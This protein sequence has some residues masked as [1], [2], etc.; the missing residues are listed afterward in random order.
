MAQ[1]RLRYVSIAATMLFAC[2]GGGDGEPGIDAAVDAAYTTGTYHA[3]FGPLTVQP[4]EENTKCVEVRLGNTANIQVHEIANHLGPMSHH[5]IVYRKSTGEAR[6]EPYDCQPFTSALNPAN[7]SPLM[8][9]QRGDEVLTLP[10]DVV[11]TLQPDQLIRLELHYIN[12]GDEPMDVTATAEFRTLLGAST[13]ADFIF[14]G[15][16]D[17]RLPSRPGIQTVGPVYLPLPGDFGGSNVF[18]ITGHT[19][20]LGKTVTVETA[21][22]K[23][24]PGTMVYDP[25]LFNWDEPD[26]I[27]HTPPFQI[28]TTGGFRFSCT[29]ENQTGNEVGFGE[30]V[31]DEMCFFW[32]YYYP[33]KGAKVCA[34]TDQ[35]NE[36][37]GLDVCCPAA[38]NDV[39]SAAACRYL[40]SGNLP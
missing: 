21:E 7:G 8:I 12:T 28:P 19:H 32:L 22:S 13:E 2:G 4:G 34:H 16:P 9:T 38:E 20:Q 27:Y 33:S 31:D 1:H 36:P 18:A 39:I 24:G 30:G 5:F 6:P 14:A 10:D 26:T 17:I 23:T 25:S 29:Y 40:E 11:F 15:S 37:D 3:T 35:F